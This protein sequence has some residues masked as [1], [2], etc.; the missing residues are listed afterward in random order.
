M[1]QSLQRD[2]RVDFHGDWTVQVA[3]LTIDFGNAFNLD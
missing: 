1:G 2:G 3:T